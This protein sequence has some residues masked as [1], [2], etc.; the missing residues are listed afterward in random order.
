MRLDSHP[1]PSKASVAVMVTPVPL[2]T[3]NASVWETISPMARMVADV[4]FS[5]LGVR[6]R[7]ESTVDTSVQSDLLE[8]LIILGQSAQ[9]EWGKQAEAGLT[10]PLTTVPNLHLR[11]RHQILSEDK[12]WRPKG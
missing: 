7:P 4:V 8:P 2:K 6:R 12:W 11:L 10:I 1:N 9:E 5:V 3:D